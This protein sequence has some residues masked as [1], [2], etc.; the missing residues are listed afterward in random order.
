MCLRHGSPYWFQ[1]LQ[2]SGGVI[3]MP[4]LP[5][6]ASGA[7]AKLKDSAIRASRRAAIVAT[8]GPAHRIGATEQKEEPAKRK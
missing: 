4:L 6:S 7:M 8:R 2:V 3:A 1:D 5:A